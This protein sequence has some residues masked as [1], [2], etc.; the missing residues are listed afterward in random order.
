MRIKPHA[1]N[2]NSEG[3]GTIIIVIILELPLS[4]LSTLRYSTW[5]GG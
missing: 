1:D 5:E 3:G 2:P 4:E